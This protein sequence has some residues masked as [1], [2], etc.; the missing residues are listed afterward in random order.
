M[1]NELGVQYVVEGSVRRAGSRVRITAQLIDAETDRHLWAERYDRE[2]A[3]IF[4]IQDEVTFRLGRS[5]IFP[6]KVFESKDA[7]SNVQASLF[8]SVVLGG[9]RRPFARS[10]PAE[11][12][13]GCTFSNRNAGRRILS[14]GFREQYSIDISRYPG[15]KPATVLQ[16]Q[17]NNNSRRFGNLVQ[18]I[19]SKDKQWALFVS[20]CDFRTHSMLS[21]R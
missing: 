11:R 9:G 20:P 4:A 6:I 19:G 15:K 21:L 3:D 18:W 13:N 1:A 2:L 16:L 12:R 14:I 8:R 10:S 7:P 17:L 5:S